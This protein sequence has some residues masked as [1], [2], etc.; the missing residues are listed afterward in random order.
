[1]LQ[2]EETTAPAASVGI[3]PLGHAL[4]GFVE[5]GHAPI[6]RTEQRSAD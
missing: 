6:G 3:A 2:Q 5:L 1:M 4:L